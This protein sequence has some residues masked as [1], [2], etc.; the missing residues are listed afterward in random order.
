MSQLDAHLIRGELLDASNE[1]LESLELFETIA[2]TNTY[3][4]AK[5]APTAGHC[6]VAIAELQTSGRGRHWRRWV[7]P[8][9]AGLSMSIAYSFAITPGGL[10]SLT[11]AVGV[12][13]AD[14]L[15]KLGIEGVSLKWP[16]DLVARDRKLGG[17]L[18]ET[19][20]GSGDGVTVVIGIGI[21]MRLPDNFDVGV[22][23]EWS[24]D[25]IDLSHLVET[26]PKH[27]SVAAAIVNSLLAVI[28]TFESSG[29][30][31]FTDDWSQLDWLAGR[32]IRVENNGDSTVGVASGVDATGRLLIATDQGE[33]S[34]LSGSVVLEPGS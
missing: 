20:S 12:A 22:R 24:T 11:L 27:E 33:T 16:N 21:N 30:A 19:Q 14:A 9:L 2:S 10:P 18:T 13:V 8:R 23:S 15:A 34:V 31:A 6:H 26:V 32:T 5:P 25:P 28:D 1:R 29:F 7:S 3:L 17:I 4:M